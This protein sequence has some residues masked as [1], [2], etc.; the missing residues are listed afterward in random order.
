MR[1]LTSLGG[2]A[3]PRGVNSSGATLCYRRQ[4]DQW[5]L[6]RDPSPRE[7]VPWLSKKKGK[8]THHSLVIICSG[9]N[10]ILKEFWGAWELS[11]SRGC[12]RLRS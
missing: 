2:R 6:E 8:Q 9:Q 5:H 12:L 1:R 4:T 7:L 3:V 10:E 11:Q